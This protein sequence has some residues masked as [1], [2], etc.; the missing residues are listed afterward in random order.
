MGSGHHARSC[1]CHVQ[2]IH[3]HAA[4][5][6]YSF[7]RLRQR[8]GCRHGLVSPCK[9]TKLGHPVR[10]CRHHRGRP[11]ALRAFDLR[12]SFSIKAWLWRTGLEHQPGPE[13]Q[14]AAAMTA[15]MPPRL[16]RRLR[17]KQAPPRGGTAGD[18]QGHGNTAGCQEPVPLSGPPTH[19]YVLT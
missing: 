7:R 10:G 15:R 6:Q 2:P 8:W 4:R 18:L 16:F 11:S 19:A 1:Q 9:Q 3:A 13:S 12:L 17:G 5:H 14:E